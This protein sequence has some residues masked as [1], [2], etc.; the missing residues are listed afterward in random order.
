[1]IVLWRTAR[2][3][4]RKIWGRSQHQKNYCTLSGP[5]AWTAAE[6]AGEKFIIARLLSA[7]SGHT[8]EGKAPKKRT[9]QFRFLDRSA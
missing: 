6:E 8:A 9:I 1:L 7:S 5:T 2:R 4:R 3:N